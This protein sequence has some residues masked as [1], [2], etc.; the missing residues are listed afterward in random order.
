MNTASQDPVFAIQR[1]YLK[2]LSLAIP[3]A[4]QSLLEQHPPTVAIPLDV[5]IQVSDRHE[6]DF[7]GVGN[8]DKTVDCGLRRAS[9]GDRMKRSRWEAVQEVVE[10]AARRSR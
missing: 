3:G 9:S 6:F 4:P 8:W 1:T 5:G 2:A 7:R 10:P